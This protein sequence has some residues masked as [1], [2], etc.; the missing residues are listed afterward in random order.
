[1]EQNLFGHPFRAR[2]GFCSGFVPQGGFVPGWNKTQI[3]VHTM[4]LENPK[5]FCSVLSRTPA[6][7]NPLKVS[8]LFQKGED[9][10]LYE[11]GINPDG[12]VLA[13]RPACCRS[14]EWV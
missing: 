7:G 3:P 6:Q 10:G 12:D 1:M 8:P 5:G 14:Q 9:M 2:W 4:D 11:P 13:H